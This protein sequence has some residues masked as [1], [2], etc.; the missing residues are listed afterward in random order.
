MRDIRELFPTDDPVEPELLIGRASDVGDLASR[1][2][3]GTHVV[4]A[5]PRRIGSA[6]ST[7]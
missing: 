7:S 6:T 5:G 2:E 3:A 1:L 4:M